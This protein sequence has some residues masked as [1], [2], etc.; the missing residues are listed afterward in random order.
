MPPVPPADPSDVEAAVTKH[1]EDFDNRTFA[2]LGAKE[3]GTHP[4]L[5]QEVRAIHSW[6]DVAPLL[7]D[8][9][10]N[11]RD[12]RVTF[13][14]VKGD[15]E[16]EKNLARIEQAQIRSFL[17][18][19]HDKPVAEIGT[20]LVQKLEGSIQFLKFSIG[21]KMLTA[22]QWVE[23]H[24][25]SVETTERLS[26]ADIISIPEPAKALEVLT[27]AD[28]LATIADSGAIS[29]KIGVIFETTSADQ[30]HLETLARA[31]TGI[32]GLVSERDPEVWVIPE[33]SCCL[34]SKNEIGKD[35]GPTVTAYR[36]GDFVNTYPPPRSNNTSG[37]DDAI[38]NYLSGAAETRQTLSDQVRS[39]SAQIDE[40]EKG[41]K[42]DPALKETRDAIESTQKKLASAQSDASKA[43]DAAESELKKL[44]KELARLEQSREAEE[45]ARKQKLAELAKRKA[46]LDAKWVEGL[47]PAVPDLREY[48]SQFS[49]PEDLVLRR[50]GSR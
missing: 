31:L 32:E 46:E 25:K 1:K 2:R 35:D 50:P 28:V 11:N 34:T 39:V 48:A 38:R 45:E 7:R 44:E 26:V 19:H 22:N 24:T 16:T 20:A 21:N 40:L 41:P 49:A 18:E 29:K 33:E 14:E 36:L 17:R 13:P 23:A 15:D 3:L 30:E 5:Y 10:I 27:R 37:L 43:K 12:I 9:Y 47:L 6:V 4:G 8:L 42:E